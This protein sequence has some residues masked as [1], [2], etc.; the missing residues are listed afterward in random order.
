MQDANKNDVLLISY[1]GYNTLQIIP[2][3]ETDLKISLTPSVIDLDQVIMTGY[4]SQK[5]K[6]IVG[7]VSVVKPKELVSVPAGQVEQM[8]QGRVAGLT[9]ITSGEPGPKPDL[10][11]WSRQFWKCY[12]ALYY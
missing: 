5:L 7:S 9:V 11:A 2:G 12:S 1:V 8:L 10:S 4:T 3:N 6:E